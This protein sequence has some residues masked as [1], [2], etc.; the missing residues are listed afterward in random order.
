MAGRKAVAGARELRLCSSLGKMMGADG[1]TSTTSRT[2][3]DAP[4]GWR[5]IRSLFRQI[6]GS[7]GRLDRTA[8][9]LL[10]DYLTV[11]QSGLFD[12][13]YYLAANPDVAAS[14]M[15]PLLHF[16]RH[17]ENES[18]RPNPILS[19]A[20]LASIHA[21]GRQVATGSPL[22]AY[23]RSSLHNPAAPLNQPRSVRLT[24]L[25]AV[26]SGAGARNRRLVV[27]TAIFDEYDA[28]RQPGV[29]SESVDYICF[30]DRDIAEPGCWQ[31]RSLDYFHCNPRRAARYAKINP[32]ICFPDHE[33]SLWVDGSVAINVD[34]LR[35]LDEYGEHE[36]L[37]AYRHPDRE[38]LAQEADAIVGA[39]LDDEAIVRI[40]LARYLDRGLPPD[41]PLHET[42]VLLRRH[43]DPAIMDHSRAWFAELQRGSLRDQ[44]SFDYAAWS[45]GQEIGTFGPRPLNVR[46]DPRFGMGGH[47]S[48][49]RNEVRHA[50][51]VDGAVKPPPIFLPRRCDDS[52]TMPVDIVVCV[53]DVAEATV[54]CLHSVNRS[55]A[56]GDR[57]IVVDDGSSGKA[58]AWL[59]RHVD[60]AAG[61][62]LI[63]REQPGG[64][65]AAANAGLKAS[66]AP[67]IA[68]LSNDA[69]VPHGWLQKLKRAA[70][71]GPAIGLVGPLSNAASFQSIFT[72]GESM[73]HV[74]IDGRHRRPVG[75]LDAL[76]A[77]LGHGL[78]P[79]VPLLDG[80]SLLIK[81]AVIDEVGLFDES[82]FP[83]GYGHD[84]DYCFRAWEA[85]F[86]S[87]LACDAY[88]HH[89]QSSG[90]AGRTRNHLW[91]SAHQ[92]LERK[93]SR[94]RLQSAVLSMDL[95]PWLTRLRA[96]IAKAAAESAVVERRSLP[97]ASRQ[98]V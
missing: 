21:L 16:L 65:T 37:F 9:R 22:A 7:S 28:L 48:K 15:D 35:L 58:A 24:E 57:L 50:T 55:R 66:S 74:A 53:R 4:R 78:Y 43:H 41:T 12:R 56:A 33:W 38:T 17:G 3:T 61:D 47:V 82:A 29:P 75:D 30:S 67:F 95:H 77:R 23:A 84:T 96:D 79:R 70:C 42:N 49:V 1:V 69:I 72:I 97:H 11:A 98:S 40:Q 14:G 6:C 54:Q 93:W 18:R 94:Q 71:A 36:T 87:V 80:A 92:A 68:L 90:D 64:Y 39:A 31:I 86:A 5:R 19:R 13:D 91:S 44:L 34:P 60:R 27:Y 20:T 26:V 62:L 46:S 10:R 45:V 8:L 73:R 81:R 59:D 52:E 32:H 89:A 25:P 51:I 76:C 83:N 88:I 85:G 63:R 2:T